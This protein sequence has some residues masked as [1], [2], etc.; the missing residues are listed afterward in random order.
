MLAAP[1]RPPLVDTLVLDSPTRIP[2]FISPSASHVGHQQPL[3]VVDSL[4]E[5]RASKGVTNAFKSLNFGVLEMHRVEFLP[6]T[7]NR[8]VIIDG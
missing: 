2:I 4:K 6:P 7:F 3:S 1:I 5:L 8:D